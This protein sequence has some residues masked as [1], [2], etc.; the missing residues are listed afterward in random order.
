MDNFVGRSHHS[1]DD[2]SQ[3][4]RAARLDSGFERLSPEPLSLSTLLC[5]VLSCHMHAMFL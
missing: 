1:T 3:G 5:H 4:L 2:T